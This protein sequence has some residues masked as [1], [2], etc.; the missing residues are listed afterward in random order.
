MINQLYDNIDNI[1]IDIPHIYSVAESA[2]RN[3]IEKIKLQMY[4]YQENQVLVKLRILN[5]YSNI[6]HKIKD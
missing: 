2:Y 5:L 1:D 6:C 3:Y 4:L